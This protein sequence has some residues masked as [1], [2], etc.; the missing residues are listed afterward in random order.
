MIKKVFLPKA[1][2]CLLASLPIYLLAGF[3]FSVSLLPINKALADINNVKIEPG[4]QPLRLGRRWVEKEGYTNDKLKCWRGT[5]IRRGNTN[6]FDARWRYDS[7]CG[8]L[9]DV[10]AVLQMSRAPGSNP[11]GILIQRTDN[12]R[13]VFCTYTGIL[14]DGSNSLVKGW[15]TCS[16]GGGEWEATIQ[17][18]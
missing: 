14:V 2:I 7:R 6:T 13:N 12:G 15:Y 18:L 1:S 11:R 10:T 4:K 5:W 16:S 3:S 8:R 9:N 17:G